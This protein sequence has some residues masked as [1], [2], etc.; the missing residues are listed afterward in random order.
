VFYFIFLLQLILGTNFLFAD[1]VVLPTE[2]YDTLPLPPTTH[3]LI[4]QENNRQ[5]EDT[6]NK[7]EKIVK[8]E[9]KEEN[10]DKK[11]KTK[12]RKKS[13]DNKSKKGEES[14]SRGLSGNGM[15]DSLKNPQLEKILRTLINDQ[16]QEL[17]RYDKTVSLSLKKVDIK[18]AFE[19]I[20]KTS[21][22][23]IFVDNDV[24]GTIENIDLKNIHISSALRLLATSNNPVLAALQ[25]NGAIRIAKLSTAIECLKS[26]AMDL[27]DRDYKNVC[28][29]I[30]HAK[31]NEELKKRLT[32]LW[33]GIVGDGSDKNSTYV[34]FDDE[35][36]KILCHARQAQIDSFKEFIGKIDIEIP[37]VKIDARIVIA[38][39]DFE[40]ALGF[41]W[42]GYYDKRGMVTHSE[43][44]GF[45]AKKNDT[46]DTMFSNAVNWAMNFVPGLSMKSLPIRLPFIWGNKNFDSNR[47]NL[48]LQ[49]AE[50]KNQIRTILKPSLLVNNDEFAEIL[51]G[52]QMPHETK[53]AETVEGQPSN[54]TTTQYKDIGMNVKIKS[55]IAPDRDSVFMDVFVEY[56]YLAKPR[57]E[58][59]TLP[60]PDSKSFNYIIETS[61]SKNRVLLKSGQTTM[62]GG[63]IINT[64][65]RIQTGVP[66]LQDI[67][68]LGFLFKARRK[69]VVEKQ[70]M[71]FITPTIS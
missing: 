42:S 32:S 6:L 29:T 50:N 2:K 51:V 53:I 26:Q 18:K 13:A 52:Q 27:L 25:E 8:K 10:S 39:K 19:L 9:L 67:P 71:I 3:D 36:K 70:L 66:I 55:I 24:Q 16:Y 47:V 1:S 11:Q 15:W 14:V 57:I 69:A 63:L 34:I 61:R 38:S 7:I 31:W 43:F 56:S 22:I 5:Q 68:I 40:E 41:D 54:V 48:I 58:F 20:S 62:I 64:E 33:K 23:Q 21:G 17:G 45:G 49:A 35:S 60:G 65:E 30:Y 28:I 12:K 4:K 37:Q 44:A 59:D 46:D